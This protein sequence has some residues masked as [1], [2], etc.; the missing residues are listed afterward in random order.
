MKNQIIGLVLILIIAFSCSTKSVETKTKDD[1]DS[2][3]EQ[4]LNWEDQEKL[5]KEELLKK[6]QDF[7]V[8]MKKKNFSFNCYDKCVDGEGVSSE[9]LRKY[10]RRKPFDI[11]RKI[12]ND[13]LRIK[14]K[15]ISDC[16]LEYIGDIEK[17]EDT[18]RLIYNNISYTP[19]DCYCYY[20][21]EYFLPADKYNSKFIYL[22]D[23]LITNNKKK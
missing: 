15:F 5:Y 1:S 13:T 12:D 8:T 10:G 19:C 2:I 11:K 17:K 18:L 4:T 9:E 16:C 14:F 6:R 20:Y 23:S 22:G 3:T 21:Y 7:I